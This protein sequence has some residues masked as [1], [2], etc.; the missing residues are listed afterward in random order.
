M[1]GDVIGKQ[2]TAALQ[3]VMLQPGDLWLCHV[4][5]DSSIVQLPRALQT[6]STLSVDMRSGVWH[7]YINQLVCAR[8]S[9]GMLMLDVDSEAA[10][11]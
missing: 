4:T 11:C 2:H 3:T 9:L 6:A 8:S 1:A 5:D 7:K 10:D